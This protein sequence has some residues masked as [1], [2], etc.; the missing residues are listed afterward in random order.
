MQTQGLTSGLK[1]RATTT[2]AATG[3]GKAA[4]GTTRIAL[5]A[6]VVG[7]A[8]GAWAGWGLERIAAPASATPAVSTVRQPVVLDPVTDPAGR[9]T[10][11]GRSLALSLPSEGAYLTSSSI[12]V[13][14]TAFGRPH[15]PSVTT[16]HVE[17]IAAGRSIESADIPVF[18]GRFAGV[19]EVPTL[20]GRTNAELRISDPLHQ[21]NKA[22]VREV[23][24][25]QR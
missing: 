19:F 11:A 24:L 21:G 9:V 7:I 3:L 12:P 6:F 16:V 1:G 18:S 17:L 5:S 10:A 15:G 22:I 8:V 13:A 20:K 23:T 14:G 4:A 2:P 25:D